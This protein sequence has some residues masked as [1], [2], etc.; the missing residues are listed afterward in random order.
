VAA[1]KIEPQDEAAIIKMILRDILRILHTSSQQDFSQNR[2]KLQKIIFIVAEELDIPLTRSWYLY[3]GY[4]HNADTTI[5]INEM[6]FS[7]EPTCDQIKNAEKLFAPVQSKYSRIM[8]ETVRKIFYTKLNTFLEEFYR[9]RAPEKYKPLYYN[10]LAIERNFELVKKF[11]PKTKGIIQQTLLKFSL[12]TN[13][14]SHYRHFAKNL[15]RLVLEIADSSD[16]SCFYDYTNR[17]IDLLEDYLVKVDLERAWFLN[18]LKLLKDMYEKAVWKPIA[19][20]ISLKT[21]TGV[22]ADKVRKKQEAI[23]SNA[24]SWISNCLDSLYETLAKNGLLL[25]PHERSQFFRTVY[26]KEEDFLGTISNVWKSYK[27]P[28]K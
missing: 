2:V 3:G 4:V 5:P 19:L 11:E 9:T 27:K 6:T 28:C 23:L 1:L 22:C 20:K 7:S 14:F 25:T 15:S 24:D 12:E 13:E 16:F 8:D 21:L 18:C 10:N 26:G 17:Y